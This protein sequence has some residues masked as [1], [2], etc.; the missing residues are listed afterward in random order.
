MKCEIS[1]KDYQLWDVCSIAVISLTSLQCQ[2]KK[3]GQWF[4][5][6][7][8]DI[9]KSPLLENTLIQDNDALCYRVTARTS[10]I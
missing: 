3:V 7:Q 4:R 9:T 6:E 1:V 5:N 8:W 10:Q 2:I